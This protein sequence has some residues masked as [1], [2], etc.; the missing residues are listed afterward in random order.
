V[1]K[2][3]ANLCWD[4]HWTLGVGV[5]AVV[6]VVVNLADSDRPTLILANVARI[7]ASEMLTL[8]LGLLSGSLRARGPQWCRDLLLEVDAYGCLHCAET[9]C[10]FDR[11]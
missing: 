8:M 6:S 1:C 9:Q 11:M 7:D 2:Q 5:Y 3:K 10:S 4:G